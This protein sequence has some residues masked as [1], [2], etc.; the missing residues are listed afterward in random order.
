MTNRVLTDLQKAFLKA[1]MSEEAKGNPKVAM[2]MAGYAPDSDVIAVLRSLRK[3]ILDLAEE[4]L[5]GHATVAAYGMT[6][7]S[8]DALHP[9]IKERMAAMKDVMDRAGVI[10]KD[11]IGS[12]GDAAK[13]ILFILPSKDEDESEPIPDEYKV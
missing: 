10:K 1:L 3:E 2:Q 11:G 9:D 12:L 6:E 7:A 4:W 13:G 8:Q 5:A